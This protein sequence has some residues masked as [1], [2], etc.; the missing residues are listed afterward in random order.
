[1]NKQDNNEQAIM[2]KPEK[3][4][5]LENLSYDLVFSFIQVYKIDLNVIASDISSLRIKNK[6]KD[7]F[8]Y[9]FSAKCF[10]S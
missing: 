1:M 2:N 7:Q 4:K 5:K 3:S 10:L 8:N 6:R 9:P